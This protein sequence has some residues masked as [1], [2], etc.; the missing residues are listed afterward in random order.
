MTG[1]GRDASIRPAYASNDLVR[2][3]ILRLRSFLT[4]FNIE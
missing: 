4:L 2:H 1:I 3:N